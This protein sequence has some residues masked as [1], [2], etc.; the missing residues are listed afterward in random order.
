MV[1]KNLN[2][3]K[4]ETEN[5][6]TEK[7]ETENLNTENLETEKL[8]NNKFITIN[9][10]KIVIKVK[11]SSLCIGFEPMTLRLTALRSTN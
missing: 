1:V 3:E 11:K 8:E 6:N 10:I 4:L 5:L 7:L 9:K 2:T